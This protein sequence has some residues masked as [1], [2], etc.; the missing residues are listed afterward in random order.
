MF[1]EKLP[2][3][4]ATNLGSDHGPIDANLRLEHKEIWST[5]ERMEYSQKGWNTRTEEARL[6]FMKG[7][8]NDLCWMDNEARGKAVLLVEEVFYSHAVEG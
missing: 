2:W 4:E 5:A 6:K 7:V 8:A 3:Y 1:E